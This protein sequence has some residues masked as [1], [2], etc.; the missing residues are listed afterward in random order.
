MGKECLIYELFG[1]IFHVISNKSYFNCQI[2]V[3]LFYSLNKRIFI[4]T[5]SFTS[6]FKTIG[7]QI[8]QSCLSTSFTTYDCN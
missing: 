3:L 6:I 8:K 1:E 5:T 4:F 7:Y 2:R